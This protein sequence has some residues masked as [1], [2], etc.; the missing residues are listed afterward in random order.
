MKK[1]FTILTVLLLTA[2][3][4]AQP[5]Q[6]ISYQA[7]IRNS[8]NVLITSA[9]I[10]M[11]ISILQGSDNGTA[12]YVETHEA[13]TNANGLVSIEIG[14]GNVQV[15]T[16]S[17]IDWASGPYFIKTETDPLGGTVY[18]IS[19]TSQLMSVPY[20]LFSANGTPGP[21]G[22][23]GP[24]GDTGPQGPQGDIGATGPAGPAGTFPAGT[25]AGEM[26]Y[27]DGTAWVAIS[28]GIT[29]QTLTF[30]NGIPTWGPCPDDGI[31]VVN[32]CDSYLWENNGQT[33]TVS[34]T[35]TG[36]PVGGATQILDLTIIPS[37]T[38][39]TTISASGSYTWAN[40][41]QTYTVSGIYTGT[42]TDCITEILDL[43][44]TAFPAIGEEYQGGILAYILQ[45]SDPGYEAGVTHGLIAA[46]YDQGSSIQWGCGGTVITGA[47]GTSIGTGLQNTLDIMNGCVGSSIAARVCYN[48]VINGYDDWYL[49]SKDE[50]NK[51]YLNRAAIGGF[52]TSTYNGYYW[53]STEYNNTDGSFAWV[54][55]FVNGYLGNGGKNGSYNV[56]AIRSF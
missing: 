9:Q 2:S 8:S 11:K 13:V 10:G 25:V 40:N 24:Q 27:W 50:L 52:S 32:A 26:M 31:T 36:N 6:K 43:T 42:T 1:I 5:P 15:G 29:G 4:F 37:T 53:S 56:R 47:D 44:I 45:P 23:Q 30:C 3:V 20:A 48:L 46:P 17:N 41:G 18:T 55:D 34:G 39:T 14:T 7:V 21:Q 12:V 22:P 49:P 19:G 51:L 28:P 35:Y 38:N 33:Y 16:F 54:R